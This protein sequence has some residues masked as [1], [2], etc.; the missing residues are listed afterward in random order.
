[1]PG[2]DRMSEEEDVFK[3][4]SISFKGI[5]DEEFNFENIKKNINL[6]VFYDVNSPDSKKTVKYMEKISQSYPNWFL[7]VIGISQND[8]DTVKK[9]VGE[10]NKKFFTVIDEKSNFAKAFNLKKIPALFLID[11]SGYVIKSYKGLDE[12]EINN[13]SKEIAESLSCDPVE[14]KLES[15]DE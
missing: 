3:L 14:I 8:S 13:I 7:S 11:K 2:G 5:D 6:L 15:K 1:M 9:F 4:S 12:G 10:D